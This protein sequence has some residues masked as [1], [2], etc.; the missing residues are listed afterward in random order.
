MD[1]YE[2]ISTR[3]SVRSFQDKDIPEEVLTRIFQAVRLAPS[4]N[5]NQEWRFIIVRDPATRKRL[6]QAA[7]QSFVGEAPVVLACCAETDLRVMKCGQLAYPINVAIAIDH[8]ALCAVQEGL[9]TC[10]IGAFDEEQAKDILGIP[11]EI[12]VVELM[13]VGYPADP[14]PISKSRFPLNDILKHERWE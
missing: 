13:P 6:A 14:K 1:I 3:K 5:N 11:K 10:W 12:R 9:G 4:G 2:A 8:F 7:Q